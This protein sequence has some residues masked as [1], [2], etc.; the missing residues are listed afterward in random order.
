M[1]KLHQIIHRFVKYSAINVILF[2]LNILLIIILTTKFTFNPLFA[3]AIGLAGVCCAHY[4]VGLYWIFPESIAH[5]HRGK[6]F[7][8]ALIITILTFFAILGISYLFIH[9][10]KFNVYTA[11]T[12]S[13]CFISIVE[14]GAHSAYTHGLHWHGLPKK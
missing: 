6:G 2:I 9:Y 7:A 11:R 4:F 5:K 3:I 12:L 10:A 13:G 1:G 14:Y 8:R